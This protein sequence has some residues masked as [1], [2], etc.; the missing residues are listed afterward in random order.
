M[1]TN[2][3]KISLKNI[4]QF[5]KF[6]TVGLLNT[7]IGLAVIYSSMYFL[8]IGP[9]ISNAIGYGFGLIV[10]YHLNRRWTFSNHLLIKSSFFNYL[11]VVICSYI[12]NI[13]MVFSVIRIFNINPYLAQLFGI[14]VYT[15]LTYIGCQKFVFRN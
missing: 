7:S 1:A 13:A 4:G 11:L 6:L 12:A 2:S 15:I 3:K 14:F 10:G 9:L 5:T 8:N